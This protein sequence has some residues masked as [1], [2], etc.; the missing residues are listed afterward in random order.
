MNATVP[1]TLHGRTC[2]H[3][4]LGSFTQIKTPQALVTVSNVSGGYDLYFF[5][6]SK[7]GPL[8]TN[9]TY[10]YTGPENVKWQVRGA[11]GS[12][13]LVSFTQLK[14]GL[15]K[16]WTYQWVAEDDYPRQWALTNADRSVLTVRTGEI[17]NKQT[18]VMGYTSKDNALDK[19][20]PDGRDHSICDAGANRAFY[21]DR[22]V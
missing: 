22:T 8:S 18:G 17:G 13:N 1:A 19:Y 6:A 2:I 4:P 16:K 10:K 12:S 5:E 11:Q 7:I 20:N 15:E 3:D 14:D 9:G 21:G